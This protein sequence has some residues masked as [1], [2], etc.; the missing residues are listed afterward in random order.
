MATLRSHAARF[1]IEF[2]LAMMEFISA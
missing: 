2:K 1:G